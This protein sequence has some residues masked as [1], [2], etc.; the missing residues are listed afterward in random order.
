MSALAYARRKRDHE[1]KPGEAIRVRRED[2]PHGPINTGSVFAAVIVF[3]CIAFL[4]G[5][6]VKGI[7]P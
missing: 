5:Y 1:Y 6:A 4:A 7:W 2:L 3:S